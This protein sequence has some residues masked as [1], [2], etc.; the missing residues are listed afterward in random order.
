MQRKLDVSVLYDK[1]CQ[2]VKC[3]A[4]MD[5]YQV[6]YCNDAAINQPMNTFGEIWI[7]SPLPKTPSRL[8]EIFLC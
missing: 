3:H 6:F 1:G 7:Q 8:S 2:H 4:Y 5:S